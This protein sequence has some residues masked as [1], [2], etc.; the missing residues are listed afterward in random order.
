MLLSQTSAVP[1]LKAVVVRQD[2]EFMVVY[3]CR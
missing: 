1:C 2:A 3:A